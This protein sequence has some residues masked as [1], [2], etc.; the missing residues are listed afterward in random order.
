MSGSDVSKDVERVRSA[1]ARAAQRAATGSAR[2]DRRVE[3]IL[4]GRYAHVH[5]VALGRQAGRPGGRGCGRDGLWVRGIT[6]KTPLLAA[7]ATVS[8]PPRGSTY[9][10]MGADKAPAAIRTYSLYYSIH[11]NQA[12]I[13][14]STPR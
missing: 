13:P 4:E 6:I 9:W 12:G 5:G 8:R 7:P 3:D 2:R 14:R 10:R 1:F 11:H